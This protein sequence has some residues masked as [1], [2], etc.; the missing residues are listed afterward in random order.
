MF[1]AEKCTTSLPSTTFLWNPR[2]FYIMTRGYIVFARLF[3]FQENMAF[4]VTRAKKNM[5]CRCRVVSPVDTNT[6]LRYDHTI[7]LSGRTSRK[8]YPV[9]L[10]RVKYVDP[11][12][13]KR[14][15]FLTNNFAL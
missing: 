6:G 2:E 9:P 7:V 14:F 13:S 10:R 1:P 5:K 8:E 4:F 15:V 12:T 11:V 3:I